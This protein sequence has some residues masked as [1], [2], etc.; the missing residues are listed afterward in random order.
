[1]NKT[2]SFNN[3]QYEALNRICNEIGEVDSEFSF[4]VAYWNEKNEFVVGK[5]GKENHKWLNYYW[6]EYIK[7]GEQYRITM[8]FKDFDH[9][10]G[11]I[12]ILPGG[13]QIWKKNDHC[14]FLPKGF[15]ENDLKQC[16]KDRSG[17]VV[18][19]MIGG[20]P[21]CEYGWIPLLETVVFW[22]YEILNEF[23]EIIKKDTFKCFD[24]TL[25]SKDFYQDVC[26]YSNKGRHGNYKKYYL[27]RM[28]DD[29]LYYKTEFIEGIGYF[30]KYDGEEVKYIKGN[31]E[32]RC[33]PN[34]YDE[35]QG[36]WIIVEKQYNI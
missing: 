20:K 23:I 21:Y 9:G 6:V 16:K 1:M 4:N 24:K 35:E 32:N 18:Y 28:K 34:Y 30:T 26:N 8:F 36:R 31:K 5:P 22:N 17:K 7:R 25:Y 3:R 29:E 33:G 12:H 14:K 15:C 2:K 10:S 13:I 11:N 19:A 27:I